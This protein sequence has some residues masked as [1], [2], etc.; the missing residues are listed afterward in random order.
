VRIVIIS[1][2]NGGVL[3]RLF[4]IKYFIDK[5]VAVVSDRECGAIG[6]AKEY[7][8]RTDIFHCKSGKKFSDD[9]LKYAEELD[10]DIFIS[11]YTKLFHG[12]FV[13]HYGSKIINLHPSILPACPG[14]DGFGDT[15]KYGGKFIGATLHFVDQGID[16]GPIII[17]SVHTYK[18][19]ITIKKNRH[20]IFIDQC[21]MLLQ[22]IK[23]IQDDRVIRENNIIDIK[24]VNYDDSPYSPNLDFVEAI[25]LNN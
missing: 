14:L 23:W 21:K 13:E 9:L 18:S 5:V 25:N 20:V 8:V 4:K 7:G 2:T 10:V 6:V 1:S 24:N 15:L 19:D 12:K 17:Q 16:T 3:S 11:F 22:V